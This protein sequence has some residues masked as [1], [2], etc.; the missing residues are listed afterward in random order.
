MRSFTFTYLSIL[1][2]A[3][4]VARVS[5]VQS[6]TVGSK[7]C[8]AAYPSP[9]TT[10]FGVFRK[11]PSPLSMRGGAVLEPETSEDVD[12]ILLRAGSEG[13]LV[14][15]DFTA[16]CKYSIVSYTQ[17]WRRIPSACRSRP[18]DSFLFGSN[19]EGNDDS[20]AFK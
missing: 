19:K 14:V 1:I 17:P 7:S 12:A 9:A 13:K 11:L 10:V 5:A 3:V 4:I 2:A 16:T 18:S 20:D 8:H 6:P 15:I